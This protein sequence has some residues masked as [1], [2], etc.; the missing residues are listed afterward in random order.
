[1]YAFHN[2]CIVHRLYVTLSYSA[3]AFVPYITS[4]YIKK[5]GVRFRS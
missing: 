3:L 2:N 5:K 1:M 4:D